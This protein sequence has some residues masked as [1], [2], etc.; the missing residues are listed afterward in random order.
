MNIYT[1]NTQRIDAEAVN[2]D[3]LAEAANFVWQFSDGRLPDGFANTHPRAAW[4]S[5]VAG[6]VAYGDVAIAIRN[7]GGAMCGVAIARQDHADLG[8]MLLLACE[9]SDKDF[10]GPKLLEHLRALVA[11]RGKTLVRKRTK[12]IVTYDPI[13]T[14]GGGPL[15]PL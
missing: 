1:S 14:G 10:L 3:T 7:N 4:F 6:S 15:E 13:Q 2:E 8:R 9:C 5:V 12:T 11:A